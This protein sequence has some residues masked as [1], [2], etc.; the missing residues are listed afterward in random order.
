MLVIVASLLVTGLHHP[1]FV[2]V[3]NPFQPPTTQYVLDTGLSISSIFADLGRQFQ[4]NPFK[5]AS[6]DIQKILDS[7]KAAIK[8][9]LGEA[10][11]EAYILEKTTMND[12][13]LLNADV[14]NKTRNIIEAA[15]VAARDQSEA[16]MNE[17]ARHMRDMTADL[18]QLKRVPG[19]PHSNFI[20]SYEGSILAYD[21]NPADFYTVR[22]SGTP[23]EDS[24]EIEII[25]DLGPKVGPLVWR[26]PSTARRA[27]DNSHQIS[28]GTGVHDASWDIPT[29][30]LA[31]FFDP[32]RKT[33]LSFTIECFRWHN[34]PLGKL[35]D[36][37]YPKQSRTLTLLPKYPVRMEGRF[38]MVFNAHIPKAI[39]GHRLDDDQKRT[40]ADCIL[41]PGGSAHIP[42]EGDDKRD[43]SYYV[44][45]KADKTPVF[46]FPLNKPFQLRAYGWSEFGVP[47]VRTTITAFDIQFVTFDNAHCQVTADMT[48][49]WDGPTMI[50]TLVPDR[51]NQRDMLTNNLDDPGHHGLGALWSDASIVFVF[52]KLGQ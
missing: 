3:P 52:R 21:D 41:Y 20:T 40:Y 48:R 7:A 12:L 26:G 6:Q 32:V 31:R 11:H 28:L 43:G 8:E 34:G 38:D 9:I 13:M 35:R 46:Y 18:N 14:Y 17:A 5:S 44:V 16:A 50:S 1:A 19:L 33:T 10:A 30:K 4:I 42:Q 25:L 49:P 2:Q 23:F 36:T 24:N 47:T 39:E 29:E 22:F 37:V 51:F 27:T 15:S 45:Y